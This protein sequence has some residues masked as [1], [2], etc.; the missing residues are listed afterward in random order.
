MH[1]CVCVCVC[2]YVGVHLHVCCNYTCL[3]YMCVAIIHACPSDVKG[4]N[5]VVYIYTS[6]YKFQEIRK[7]IYRDCIKRKWRQ[8]WD[9]NE[10]L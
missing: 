5:V 4:V 9:T 2:V 1:V 7:G 8:D 3:L 10:T 6:K